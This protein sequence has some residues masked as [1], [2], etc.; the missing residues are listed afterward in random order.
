MKSALILFLVVLESSIFI[1][2]SK[3]FMSSFEANWYRAFQSCAA[4]GK[5][6][7][8]VESQQKHDALVDYIKTTS[9]YVNFSRFWLGANDMAEEGTFVWVHSGRTVTYTRWHS[10]EPNNT[11][12]V[13]NCVELVYDTVGKYIWKWN[14]TEC[15][16]NK[17][18]FVCEDDFIED[19]SDDEIKEF[20]K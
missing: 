2:D 17:R 13:E 4:S 9:R 16:D 5:R 7:V 12:G 20:K 19:D 3:F 6:L 11:G 15:K 14:D 10:D 8:S 18:Y 1:V